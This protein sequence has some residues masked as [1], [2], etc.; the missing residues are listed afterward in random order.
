MGKLLFW[1]VLLGFAFVF[2]GRADIQYAGVNLSGAEFGQQNEPGTFGSDYTWPTTAEITYYKSKGMNFI[3][4]PFRWERLQHT[5]HAV[6]DPTELGRM[7]T[8]VTNATAR[9][10]YV[11]LDP[12]NFMRYYPVP[13][14]NFQTTTNGLV[15]AT[16]PFSDFADFWSRIA[17]IYKTNDHVFFGLNNEP[18]AMPETDL[19]TAENMAI[20]AIRAAG[21][22]NLIFVPGNAY[23]GAWTWSNSNGRNGAANSVAMLGIVDS[24][25]N[26]IFEVHQYLD[27]D[28]SGTHTNI[29]PTSTT[30]DP[31]VGWQRLANFTAW[32]RANHVK[33]FLGEFAVA[34]SMIGTGA[35][36]IG[37]EA[38]NSMLGYMQ[39]N[40][41]VWLGWAWWGGGP[42]WPANSL[43][44]I[45]AINL[46]QSNQTD[47]PSMTV[48]KQ[49]FPL[50]VPSLQLANGN[51]FQFMGPQGFIYQPQFSTDLT[52][53]SW[54]SYG[55]SL[56][57]RVQTITVNISMSGSSGFYRVQVNHAP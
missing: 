46:G 34:D 25:S 22:T 50:P 11:L 27:Y 35:T 9:G 41:D 32:A 43:F 28:G 47:K 45:D 1:L 51:Q 13:V 53:G 42:W 36:Q 40:S 44:L 17:T 4:L 55:S 38:L 52:S 31:N 16:V 6:L 14:G 21:A 18:D 12:H 48:I 10:M 23:T 33:G 2:S 19:V 56:T 8:F 24:G 30:S 29:G 26:Y 37:D 39:T 5:N 7:N 57:G 3:R 54:S 15:G 49:F 20:A